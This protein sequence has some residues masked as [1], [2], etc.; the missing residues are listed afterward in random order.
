VLLLSSHCQEQ[1][2]TTN[3]VLFARSLPC[4]RSRASNPIGFR[5]A[6]LE[7]VGQESQGETDYKIEERTEYK[8]KQLDRGIMLRI[9]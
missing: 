7:K 1:R 3:D 4:T 5:E 2:E 6:R 8:N 9:G